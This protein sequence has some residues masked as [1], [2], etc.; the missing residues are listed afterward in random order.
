MLSPANIRQPLRAVAAGIRSRQRP[1]KTFKV[2][3]PIF[4]FGQQTFAFD[5]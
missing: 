3:L 2:S 1:K 5:I 4:G